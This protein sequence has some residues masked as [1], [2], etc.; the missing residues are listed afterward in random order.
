MGELTATGLKAKLATLGKSPLQAPVRIGDGSG[1]HLLVKANQTSGGAWVLRYSYGGKRRDMGL[2][3]YPAVGLADARAAAEEARK[4]LRSNT[5]PLAARGAEKAAQARAAAEAEI[6]ATTFREAALATV[7]AK[8]DGWSNPKHAAQWL[9]TLEQHAFPQL[10]EMPIAAVDVPAVLRVL[11]PIWPKIPETASRLRQRIEAVLDL[12][13]VRGWRSGENP[14][15]WR[16]LLSE[17]LPPSRRVKRVEHRPAL[18]WQQMP[19]FWTALSN[20]DGMGAAALRFAIL[21]A[22]RTGEVRGMTWREVDMEASLWTVPSGRMKAR[23]THRVPLSAAAIEVLRAVQPE[24]PRSDH[25]IFSGGDNVMLSDM[26]VSAVLRR[27]NEPA[28]GENPEG[29]PRWRDHEGRAI[30]PHGFRSTFR[31][32]AGE[33]REEGR[34]VI[35]RA[36]AHTVKDKVEAAYARSDLLEKRRPLMEAWGKWCLQPAGIAEVRSAELERSDGKRR[37]AA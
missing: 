1:L 27:M 26:T 20:V 12:A 30:V 18:S 25:L 16:G 14:A 31:D 36:L 28:E 10:G 24:R 37:K 34:D 23:R 5:D 21:T 22:A 8:R 17:E 35:E 32:W 33:T 15:R 3:T 19:A 11:R 2:G 6:K 9:A 7:A 13:R 29:P 4:L